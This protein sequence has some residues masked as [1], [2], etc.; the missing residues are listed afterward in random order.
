MTSHPHPMTKRRIILDCDPGIDDC[1]S[2]LLAFASPEDFDI[3][4]VTTVAGN[5]PVE[6]CTRNASGT[7]ALAGRIDVA[8]YQGASSPISVP[9]AFAQDI[10]GETGLGGAKLPDGPG[11]QELDAVSFLIETLTGAEPDSTTL[12]PTGPLTNIALAFQGV[13]EA[14]TAVER[15]ALM[16]GARVAGGNITPSA[17]FNI[18]ADPHAAKIVFDCGRPITAI[19]L[20]A[21][22]QLRCGPERMD[23]IR[24]LDS[25]AGEAVAAM[26]DHV[27][28]VYGRIYGAKG[29]AL[30]DPCTVAW[31]LAPEL[32][33]GREVRVDIETGSDLT[34]GHTAVDYYGVTGKAPNALWIDALDADAVFGLI[35]ERL[36]QL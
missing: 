29:A 24:A 4:G 34:R 5:V 18:F 27:N 31:L 16:G 23:R 30:H 1:V 3:L 25:E 20:D 2:L 22:L 32:F 17:E 36:A 9:P 35:L 6:A 11:A 15:I 12:V 8:I 10:H 28:E 33:S 21:T 26:I 14:F 7:A 19:G 13:P